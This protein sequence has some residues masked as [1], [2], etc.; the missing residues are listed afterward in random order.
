MMPESTPPAAP[1]IDATQR[2]LIV[3]IVI[4]TLLIAALMIAGLA[5]GGRPDPAPLRAASTLLDGP[6]RFHTG[7]DPRW[8]AANLDASGWETIDLTAPPG[9]H[10]GDVGLPDYV[11][12]WS[13][14]GHRGYHGYAWYRRAVTVPAG[15]ASWDIL[16][17][18]LVEDGYEL[19]WNGQRLGGSGRLGPEPRLVGTRPLR[20]ALPAGAAGTSGVLAV[21]TYMLPRPG[22]SADGGGMHAAPILAPRPVGEALH[23]AQWQRT[24]AGYVVDAVEPAAMLALAGL[25][26]AVGSR[27]RRKGFLLFA[28]IALALTAAR[29]LD[30]AIVSWTDLQDL[31]TYAWLAKVMWAPTMTAWLL[32]WNRWR[33]PAWRSI[34]ALAIALGAAGIVGALAHLPTWASISRLGSLA[35]FAVIVVRIVRGGPLRTLA[36]VTPASVLAALFGGELLDP[37]GV[38]GIWFPFNI[39]VSRT[40]YIYAIGIPLLAVLIARTLLPKDA[41]ASKAGW[42]QS[43]TRPEHDESRNQTI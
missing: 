8:A 2:K 12:G 17:P 32:A 15:S 41:T 18:T 13:A 16:G 34:D 19:Y 21:R 31:R 3:G 40:Q 9:S 37:L 4:V 5:I 29:R 6:W 38:P 24:I 33:L 27:S 30:N 28:G 39:G 35:L 7:D 22:P 36:L 25:A 1:L 10:D 26:L 20:F 43:S 14:H 11:G 42:W 23:R